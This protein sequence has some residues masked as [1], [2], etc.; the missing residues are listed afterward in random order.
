MTR[1]VPGIF[2][3]SIRGDQLVQ[4]MR[5]RALRQASTWLH[6]RPASL[7]ELVELVNAQRIV[8]P[9]TIERG[10]EYLNGVIAFSHHAKLSAP[11]SFTLN[12]LNSA[13]AFIH[14][15][16]LSRILQEEDREFWKARFPVPE[17]YATRE[18]PARQE[19][20]EERGV[21]DSHFH[22][23]RLME[24]TAVGNVSEVLKLGEVKPNRDLN[25]IAARANFVDPE[26][27]PT[28][29]FLHALPSN[30]MV[31]IGIHPKAAS[32]SKGFL[33]SALDKLRRLS[34][35]SWGDRAG[36]LRRRL[37]MVSATGST[38]GPTADDN[39]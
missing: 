12:P 37:P 3:F 11:E 2:D 30:L 22:L 16:I 36:L 7:D 34:R 14:R 38:P 26:K 4:E 10:D 29:E 1:H 33:R 20:P 13:G 39:A 25:V 19:E 8:V 31:T 32:R 23:G 18:I 5:L 21:V 35:R 15:K 9:Q 28:P 6:G 17:G 27:F 24:Y